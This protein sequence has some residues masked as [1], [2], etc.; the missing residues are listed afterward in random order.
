MA[1]LWQV[2]QD[3][4]PEFGKQVQQELVACPFCGTAL[5]SA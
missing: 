5:R 2:N 4:V 1:I 3:D